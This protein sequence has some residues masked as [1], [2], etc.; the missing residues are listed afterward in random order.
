MSKYVSKPD[1]QWQQRW[2]SGK[3]RMTERK[4][5]LRGRPRRNGASPTPGHVPVHDRPL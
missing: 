1:K 4:Q 2:R 3:E 5:A